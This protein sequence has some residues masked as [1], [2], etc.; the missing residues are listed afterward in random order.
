MPASTTIRMSARPAVTQVVAN[1][2]VATITGAAYTAAGTS[3]KPGPGAVAI[4]GAAYAATAIVKPS[5]GLVAVTASSYLA[6][7][8]SASPYT[9]YGFGS[10]TSGGAAYIGSP[11]VVSNL[12]D[13]GAGSLRA[14]LSG[15]NRYITFSVGGTITLSSR[16]DITSLVNV[17]LDGT[18]APSPGITITASG[19]TSGSVG[20]GNIRLRGTGVHDVIIKGLR[21]RNEGTDTDGITLFVNTVGDTAST[22]NIVIDHCSFSGHGKECIAVWGPHNNVTIS[23]CIFGPGWRVE[24][25]YALLISSTYNASPFWPGPQNVTVYRNLFYRGTWRQA[26]IGW[27]DHDG[28]PTGTTAPGLV[29]D[30]RNNLIWDHWNDPTNPYYAAPWNVRGNG[31][32]VYWGSK[33]NVVNN[34]Y[35]SAQAGHRDLIIENP[36]QNTMA[37]TAGNYAKCGDLTEPSNHAEFPVASY[38]RVP[39]QTAQASAAAMLADVGGRGG[40]QDSYD[41]AIIAAITG[42]L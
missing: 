16:I 26:A 31:T 12:N 42:N 22:Y 29:V 5:A 25:N 38:A 11:T 6:G 36:E 8:Q 17:T 40:G 34:Y 4:S 28:A 23:N 33:A 13:S 14:A 37:Y 30:Q 7:T 15:S 39:V 21:F 41:A 2:G 35:W 19:G 9:I 32:T 3:V 1:A 20:A 24:H 18:T 27:D 10:V